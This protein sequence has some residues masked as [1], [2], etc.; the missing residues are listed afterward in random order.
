[1]SK[2]AFVTCIAAALLIAAPTFATDGQVLINQ[3]SVMAVGGFPYKITQSG[4]YKL[5]G[6][7]VVPPNTDGIDINADNVTLDLGG[8]SISA[9]QSGGTGVQSAG[10]SGVTVRDGTVTGFAS[11]VSVS[12]A[13]SFNG[14][15]PVVVGGGS[16]RI[17]EVTARANIAGIIISGQQGSNVVERCIAD[18][19]QVGFDVSYATITQSSA[20]NNSQFGMLVQAVT[21]MNSIVSTNQRTGIFGGGEP[22]II[23]SNIFYGNAQGD[24]AAVT[25]QGN[26]VCSNGSLC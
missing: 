6:N 2:I 12:S 18:G 7:L 3:S 23:G 15:L 26:N 22:A 8:F 25:S 10:H 24:F 16:N 20:S 5:S 17:S 13:V 9:A 19:N 11:G 14:G 21:I 1:M 4:S